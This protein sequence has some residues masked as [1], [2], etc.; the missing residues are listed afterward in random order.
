MQLRAAR[1]CLD[2]EEV[3]DFGQCP[4]CASETFTYLVRWIPTD[5]R[6]RRPRSETPQSSS[7]VQEDLEAYRRLTT[8]G[9]APPK[10]RHLVRKGVVG[11]A[12]LGV[13]GWLWGRQDAG[14]SKPM[15][16]PGS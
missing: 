2:C 7:P 1:L 16:K 4:V 3:H 14:P 6:R 12:A 9:A 8:P 10:G 5:E 11:L 15:R 13:V